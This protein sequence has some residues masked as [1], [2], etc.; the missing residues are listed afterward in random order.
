M[1]D[2][3]LKGFLTIADCGSINKAAEQLFLSQPA[4]KK[5]MDLLE[6]ELNTTL[7]LRSGHGCRLTPA[8]EYFYQ[9][10]RQITSQ[11]ENAIRHLSEYRISQLRICVLNHFVTPYLDNFCQRY[12]TLYPDTLIE[13]IPCSYHERISYVKEEKADLCIH[14]LYDDLGDLSPLQWSKT[15]RFL[16][17]ICLMKPEHHLA[18]RKSVRLED[19]KNERVPLA[20]DNPERFRKM[21]PSKDLEEHLRD[22][23]SLPANRNQIINFCRKGGAYLSLRGTEMQFSDTLK[24]VPIQDLP[25]IPIGIL[26]SR[27]PS[28][29]VQRFL[30]LYNT[31]SESS[32][33]SPGEERISPSSVTS[34]PST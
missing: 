15:Q 34:K 7:F 25:S 5:Q 13:Y 9:Q 11:L 1:N 30:H 2:K 32:G 10:T 12:S 16:S 4:L 22:I 14:V 19:L 29:E 18:N 17:F 21:Y 20:V 6:R 33:K 23:Q 26:Y 24:A 8:G 3:Q 27:H 28:I 31:Q